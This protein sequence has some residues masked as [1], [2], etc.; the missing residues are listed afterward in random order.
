[1]I[2]ITQVTQGAFAAYLKK[3]PSKL[4]ADRYHYLKNWDWSEKDSPKPHAGNGSLPVTYVGY[5]EA[6]AY[7]ASL[8]RFEVH[9]E[10]E[11]KPN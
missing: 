7:C 3:D 2:D 8:V 9:F 1:M 4:S 10:A 6:K 11:D 5:A